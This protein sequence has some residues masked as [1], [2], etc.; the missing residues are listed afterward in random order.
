[1]T[2]KPLTIGLPKGRNFA[3][4]VALLKELG[5][6][7]PDITKSDRQLIQNSLCGK[8]KLVILR[9][10]DLPS[11]IENGAVD[12]SIIGKDVLWEQQKDLYEPLDLGFGACRLSV[13]GVAERKEEYKKA[14]SVRIATKFVNIAEAFFLEKGVNIEIISLKGGMEIAPLVGLSDYIVDLISTGTTLRENGLIE[15]EKIGDISARLVVNRASFKLRHKQLIPLIDK[16]GHL[17]ENGFFA[18]C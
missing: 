4:I 7:L 17:Q 3:T 8:L 11:Y 1:M 16:I 6:S 12:M 18:S 9:D 2:Q 14:S 10:T 5:F 15:Y 13:A